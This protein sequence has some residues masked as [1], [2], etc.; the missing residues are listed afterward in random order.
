MPASGEY[1]S[2]NNNSRVAWYRRKIKEITRKGMGLQ[3]NTTVFNLFFFCK[4]KPQER[5]G[6]ELREAEVRVMPS[7]K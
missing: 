2:I 7:K 6:R 5:A 3:T 4:A 1:S